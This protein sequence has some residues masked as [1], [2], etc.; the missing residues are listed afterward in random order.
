MEKTSK[1]HHPQEVLDA[2]NEL[3]TLIQPIKKSLAQ[4]TAMPEMLQRLDKRESELI[5]N[6]KKLAQEAETLKNANN[7]KDLSLT[8]KKKELI[9]NEI[10]KNKNKKDTIKAKVKADSQGILTDTVFEGLKKAVN[11]IKLGKT[12]QYKQESIIEMP[13]VNEQIS[14]A[15]EEALLEELDEME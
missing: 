10:V 9:D 15:D 5:Q 11:N 14:K 3:L 6:S 1:D 7:M 8:L 13:K 4:I 12:G 2:V